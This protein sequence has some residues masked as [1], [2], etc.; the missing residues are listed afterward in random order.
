MGR[1]LAISYRTVKISLGMVLL[2]T[3]GCAFPFGSTQGDPLL[4]NFNRPIRRT[5]PPERGGLGP[6]S[7]AYDGGAHIGGAPFGAPVDVENSAGFLSLPNLTSPNLMSAGNGYDP[8]QRVMAPGAVLPAPGSSASLV[9]SLPPAYAYRP[10]SSVASRPSN[11]LAYITSGG[12]IDAPS[13]PAKPLP[14]VQPASHV[15]TMEDAAPLLKAMNLQFQ[16]LEQAP[17]GDWV[18]SCVRGDQMF[19]GHGKEQ[20]H[21]VRSVI[22]AVQQ[23]AAK[24]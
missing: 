9:P 15:Q 20:I 17:N 22:D 18:F 12:S 10:Q 11:S 13:Q 21:A 6:G 8:S 24:E 7:P 19:E 1:M 14:F 5:P 23:A 3:V 16:R 2:G 4:G